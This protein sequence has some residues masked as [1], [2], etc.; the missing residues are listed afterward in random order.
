VKD[1]ALYIYLYNLPDLRLIDILW[2]VYK[3]LGNDEY[4]KST[5]CVYRYDEVIEIH[6]ESIS[7]RNSWV[8]TLGYDHQDGLDFLGIGKNGEYVFMP[9]SKIK[10]VVRNAKIAMFLNLPDL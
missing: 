1:T 4:S 2:E 9:L 6:D 10:A 3:P 7:D 5:L 8:M